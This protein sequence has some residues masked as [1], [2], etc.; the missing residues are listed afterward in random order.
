[1]MVSPP[2]GH[3][4]RGTRIAPPQGRG[5]EKLSPLGLA[6]PWLCSH[7]L[8]GLPVKVTSIPSHKQLSRPDTN[9]HFFL[10]DCQDT[11]ATTQN[12]YTEPKTF[13]QVNV[14]ILIKRHQKHLPE[15]QLPQGLAHPEAGSSW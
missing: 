2:P 15:G 10:K 6:P 9:S 11:G 1:M 4:S 13:W 12:V 7:P 5:S 8:K 14:F 3:S